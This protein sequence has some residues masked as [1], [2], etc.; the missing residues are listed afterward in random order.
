MIS[1]LLLLALGV[2]PDGG[3]IT[4]ANR[5]V[6]VRVLATREGETHTMTGSGLIVRSH[7]VVVATCFH[8]IQYAA[9]IQV[10]VTWRGLTLQVKKIAVLP[11]NDLAF[12]LLDR[13]WSKEEGWSATEPQP[14]DRVQALGFGHADHWTLASNDLKVS[15]ARTTLKVL[16]QAY[17]VEMP[18][19]TFTVVDLQPG[20]LKGLREGESGGPVLDAQGRL[21]GI[22]AG[23]LVNKSG[24]DASSIALVPSDTVPPLS[25][26]ASQA[27]GGFL[28]LTDRPLP[29]GEPGGMWPASLL[30]SFKQVSSRD[31]LAAE[32]FVQVNAAID[33]GI[34]N[35]EKLRLSALAL[36][37][38][39]TAAKRIEARVLTAKARNDL[40]TFACQTDKLTA[41]T[42]LLESAERADVGLRAAVKASDADAA[43]RHYLVVRAAETKVNRLGL[44]SDGCVGQLTVLTTVCSE[45]IQKALALGPGADANVPARCAKALKELRAVDAAMREEHRR[46]TALLDYAARLRGLRAVFDRHLSEAM[47]REGDEKGEVVD[48]GV[49]GSQRLRCPIIRPDATH[50]LE[51]C[52]SN[53]CDRLRAFETPGKQERLNRAI[54]AFIRNVGDGDLRTAAAL[55]PPDAIAFEPAPLPAAA[56]EAV[57]AVASAARDRSKAKLKQAFGPSGPGSSQA[58]FHVARLL[59]T[60][61]PEGTAAELVEQAALE[62]RR[63]VGAL[64]ERREELLRQASR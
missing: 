48:P 50:F 19:A 57:K 60:P 59:V 38:I 33:P 36:S 63:V 9:K 6:V 26:F 8:V 64:A 1:A 32:P 7:P 40:V 45:G 31:V 30:L 24:N 17:G 27:D 25:A 4:L 23:L 54:G 18:K 47:D 42:G 14:D 15:Q 44:E 53:A 21:V 28:A 29:Y 52:A 35:A 37:G 55:A 34:P 16:A 39:G 61:E 49:C 56:G 41:I 43:A 22:A 10:Q 20:T 5:D 62:R 51:T 11:D 46:T 12:L 58:A 2:H 3:S 13:D